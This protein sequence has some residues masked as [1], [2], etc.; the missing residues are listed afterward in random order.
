M[1]VM[2]IRVIPRNRVI[3][4]IMLNLY[5]YVYCLSP[6]H[7]KHFRYFHLIYQPFAPV[8]VTSQLTSRMDG[9]MDQVV[10]Y[11]PLYQKYKK[12]E[13]T[14]HIFIT[15]YLRHVH[16]CLIQ[17]TG[18]YRAGISEVLLTIFCLLGTYI[19]TLLLFLLTS[20]FSFLALKSIG[21]KVQNSSWVLFWFYCDIPEG[22][23]AVCGAI[24]ELL[25][26]KSGGN[27]R[28]WR[29]CFMHT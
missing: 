8:L 28:R 25:L 18:V 23:D 10:I 9:V 21:K 13:V 14:F 4:R 2:I 20:F 11:R 19:I 15:I 16:M 12:L 5:V 1:K 17:A 7:L 3:L 27:G 24:F 26:S 29:K 22:S 6:S